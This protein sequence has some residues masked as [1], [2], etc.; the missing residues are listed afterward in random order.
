VTTDNPFLASPKKD[1]AKKS[2]RGT[3]ACAL[4]I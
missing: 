3:V 2:R 1:A 4:E